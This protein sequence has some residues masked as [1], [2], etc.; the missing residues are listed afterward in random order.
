MT[1]DYL[2]DDENV[3]ML[4]DTAARIGLTQLLLDARRGLRDPID[5][6]SKALILLGEE[7]S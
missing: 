3:K 1:D 2:D 5:A 4:R 6:I 7:S